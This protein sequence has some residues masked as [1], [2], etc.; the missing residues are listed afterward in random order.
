MAPTNNTATNNISSA[1]N[2]FIFNGGKDLP[3]A[4]RKTG[5]NIITSVVWPAHH[6]PVK[7]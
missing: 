4:S 3:A 7:K 2:T 6:R 5:A 1:G